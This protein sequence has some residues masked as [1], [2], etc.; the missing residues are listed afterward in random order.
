[1]PSAS[2]IGATSG[3]ACIAS[4]VST[5]GR[6]PPILSVVSTTANGPRRPAMPLRPFWPG[7]WRRWA[8]AVV[9]ALAAVVSPGAGSVWASRPYEAELESLRRRIELTDVVERRVVAMTPAERRQFDALMRWSERSQ[10][11]SRGMPDGE[12]F[13]V[14]RLSRLRLERALSVP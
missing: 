12:A 11:A 2:I 10:R 4:Q 14:T 7:A 5:T 6:R 9:F 1:M 3:R 8:V 13:A